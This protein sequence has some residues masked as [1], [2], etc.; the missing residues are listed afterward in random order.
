MET[1]FARGDDL[2]FDLARGLAAE[3]YEL[4]LGSALAESGNE[5]EYADQVPT[6]AE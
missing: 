1:L 6:S 3:Q 5:M 2:V 4:A